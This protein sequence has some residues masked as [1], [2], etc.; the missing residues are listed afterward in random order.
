[1]MWKLEVGQGQM[2][3]GSNVEDS[4]ELV[5]TT[6]LL[7]CAKILALITCDDMSMF[8]NIQGLC[9]KGDDCL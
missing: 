9:I 3:V 1:M 2:M 5:M 8:W 6:W 4:C 7:M